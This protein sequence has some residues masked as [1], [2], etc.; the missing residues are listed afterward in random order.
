MTNISQSTVY[1]PVISAKPELK[2]GQHLFDG[3]IVSVNTVM[4]F[5]CQLRL[6]AR[7]HLLEG[8]AMAFVWVPWLLVIQTE[9]WSA[10]SSI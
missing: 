6:S 9:N 2:L 3:R 10:T 7:V 1:F 5:R 4:R 8:G